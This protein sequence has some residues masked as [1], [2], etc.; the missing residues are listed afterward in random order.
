MDG[1]R[2]VTDGE[3]ARGKVSYCRSPTR[4]RTPSSR[5]CQVF[6]RA[7]G[8]AGWG[9]G[10]G[11]TMSLT[12]P[13]ETPP[14]EGSIGEVHRQPADGGI[15]EHPRFWAGLILLGSIFFA[16]YFIGRIFGYG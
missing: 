3:S 15:W 14:A 1:Q 4:E 13:G 16:A 9:E 6:A 8:A 11:M 2:R 7:A 5:C 12:P 10:G